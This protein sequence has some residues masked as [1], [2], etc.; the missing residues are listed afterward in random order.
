M[1]NFSCAKFQF[2]EKKFH[3]FHFSEKNFT[4]FTFQKKFIFSNAK[5]HFSERKIS[6]QRKISVVTVP[7][8]VVRW[9][10]VYQD[11]GFHR[12]TELACRDD[13]IVDF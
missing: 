9:C 10:Y 7:S 12:D 1:Q 2:S 11:Q 6:S 8:R 5:F 3:F 13:R 4:F